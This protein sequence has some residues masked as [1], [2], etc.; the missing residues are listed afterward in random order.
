MNLSQKQG[1][2]KTRLIHQS[3]PW[4]ELSYLKALE[5]Q[6]TLTQEGKVGWL[7]FA[8]P[9]TVT[10]GKRT[11]ADDL[12]VEREHLASQQVT[13]LEVDRGGRATYH[14][15]SQVIGFPLGTLKD[16]VGD[17]RGVHRFLETLTRELKRFISFELRRAQSKAVV[18][19]DL[20][21]LEDLQGIWV[22]EDG[23]KKKL[24]SFGM[25]FSREGIAHGFAINVTS[26]TQGFELIHPCGLRGVQMASLFNEN[27]FSENDFAELRNRLEKF[28]HEQT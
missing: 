6:K 2:S 10:L 14:S 24:V 13:L 8:C 28:L 1:E 16:H 15:P 3:L 5:L 7:L 27:R 4:G 9:P 18:I 21:A 26:Q 22:D 11:Q 19:E 25:R 12:R 20:G 23:I 17:S